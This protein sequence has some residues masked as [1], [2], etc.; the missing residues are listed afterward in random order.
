MAPT[1]AQQLTAYLNAV[2]PAATSA[3]TAQVREAAGE[4]LLGVREEAKDV[5]AMRAA[6]KQLGLAAT[7]LKRVARP[8][9]L[10][11]PHAALTAGWR[12]E[13]IGCSAY[14]TAVE[15]QADTPETDYDVAVE[16]ARKGQAHWRVEV[17]AQL[18]RLGMVVPQWVRDVGTDPLA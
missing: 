18:R 15:N 10:A 7:A 8:V 5:A 13:A 12:S 4:I 2:K 3:R 11:E 9:F 1:K 17:I 16:S 14:A 6:C